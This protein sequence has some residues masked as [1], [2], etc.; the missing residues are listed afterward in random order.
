MWYDVFKI[1]IEVGG[2]T[3]SQT[4]DKPPRIE[5]QKLY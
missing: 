4:G 2:D 5:D 1:E 3:N